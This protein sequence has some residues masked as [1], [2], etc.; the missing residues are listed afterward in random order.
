MR[1]GVREIQ[2]QRLPG[3]G[4]GVTL[5]DGDRLIGE[6]RQYVLQLQARRDTA[7]PPEGALDGGPVFAVVGFDVVSWWCDGSITPNVKIGRN[8][9]RGADAEVRVEAAICRA[10][11]ERL[12]VAVFLKAKM[13][14]ADHRCPVAV[15][16][17][18]RSDRHLSLPDHR[19]LPP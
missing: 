1:R 13:P 9:G 10:A 8:I 6:T 19:L 17:Q 14:L 7:R 2:H 15:R 5:D 18:Q 11:G 12:V 3:F 4:L 16:L